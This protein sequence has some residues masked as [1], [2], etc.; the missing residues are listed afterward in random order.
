MIN[1]GRMSIKSGTRNFEIDAVVSIKLSNKCFVKKRISIPWRYE[2]VYVR[3]LRWGLNSDRNFPDKKK[4]SQIRSLIFLKRL[5]ITYLLLGFQNRRAFIY[6]GQYISQPPLEWKFLFLAYGLQC[7]RL[8]CYRLQFRTP[9]LFPFIS[10]VIIRWFADRS[11]IS[12]L[13]LLKL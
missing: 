13:N 5:I 7:Y 1:S 12:K 9:F 8:H 6:A 10:I 11:R 2:L 3:V 4:P